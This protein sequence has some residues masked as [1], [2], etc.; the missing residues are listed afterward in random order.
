MANLQLTIDD[1]PEP[2]KGALIPIL[3]ELDKRHV[4]AA[5]FVIGSEAATSRSAI[6]EIKRR[7]HVIGNHSWDH[8][9]KGTNKYSDEEVI[10]QFK[11][12][13]LEVQHAGYT[14]SHWRAPRG[15]QVHRLNDIIVHYAKLYSFTHTEWHAD[16]KDSLG[17]KEA[18]VMITN[19]QRDLRSN[20]GIRMLDGTRAHRLLFHVK[21]DTA[22]ALPLVLD[23]LL[24]KG[25]KL[26]DFSQS[27]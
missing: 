13:Q 15:Q 17:A 24:N 7:N 14:M 12:T 25:H 18:S 5:F 22:S 20:P 21:P 4:V 16:S 19:L 2:V 23:N 1:G 3:D 6:S 8:M 11:R 26:L 10:D 27:M 9:E